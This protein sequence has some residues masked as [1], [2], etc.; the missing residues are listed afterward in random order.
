[1]TR[2]H[3]GRSSLLEL[4]PPE[5]APRHGDVPEPR[6][7]RNGDGA[8]RR[9]RAEGPAS[10]LRARPAPRA[11]LSAPRGLP[12]PGGPLPAV[13]VTV[14][15]ASRGR[16]AAVSE[17]GVQSAGCSGREASGVPRARGTRGACGPA[18]AAAGWEP[19]GGLDAPS[20]SRRVRS[21]LGRTSPGAT[22]ASQEPPSCCR[23]PRRPSPRHL[24][25]DVAR[26]LPPPWPSDSVTRDPLRR[27]SG[28]FRR[29]PFTPKALFWSKI[30][31]SH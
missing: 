3:A 1:M 26:T 15:P 17:N 18:R 29:L 23:R 5:R 2:G 9:S 21:V 19:G 7:G 14:A 31:L 12:A 24:R 4:P 10:G 25:R 11:P 16:G 22:A 27:S 20:R 28:L 13:G 6:H 30:M 8:G